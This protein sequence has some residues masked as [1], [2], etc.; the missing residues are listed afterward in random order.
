MQILVSEETYH[1]LSNPDKFNFK[2]LTPIL[3][4]G[5]ETPV[6]IFEIT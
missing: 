1:T 2:K 5:I 4:K 3:L 6:P